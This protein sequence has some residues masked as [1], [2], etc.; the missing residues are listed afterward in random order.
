MTPGIAE[1]T[2]E[3][4]SDLQEHGVTNGVTQTVAWT[5]LQEA[6][7]GALDPLTP[8]RLITRVTDNPNYTYHRKRWVNKVR[9]QAIPQK[10]TQ[11]Q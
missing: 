6:T 10:A 5:A 2:L 11:H 8:G 1:Q 7:I 3:V 9:T 4:L